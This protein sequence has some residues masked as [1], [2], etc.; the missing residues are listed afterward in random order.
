[1]NISQ[2]KFDALYE[3]IAKN[4]GFMG[5]PETTQT[6][7]GIN[8]DSASTQNLFT[9]NEYRVSENEEDNKNNEIREALKKIKEILDNIKL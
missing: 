8:Q 6:S 3:N 9:P 5:N 2:K 1:M 4:I 7:L